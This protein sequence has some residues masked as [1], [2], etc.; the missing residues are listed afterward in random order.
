MAGLRS[1]RLC[2][3]SG[4]EAWHI[5]F[6]RRRIST[7]CTDRAGAEKVLAAFLNQ[8]SVNAPDEGFSIAEILNRYLADRQDEGIAGLERLEWAHKPLQRIWAEKPPEAIT[9]QSCRAYA[10]QRSSDGVSAGTIRTELQAL[11]AALNWAHRKGVLS[12]AP[13]IKMPPK[14]PSKSRWLTRQEA[15]ALLAE[16][17]SPHIHLFVVLALNT[18][19]RKS[20]ILGLQWHKVD[21]ERRLI[22]FSTG[23]QTN[24][25]RSKVPIN[26]TLL[27]ALEDAYKRKTTDY[28]IEYGGVPVANIKRSF[29]EACS[30]AGLKDATPHTL[31]HTA[32]TWM[33]Q[34]GV[35]LWE[36]AGFLGH[37][38]IDMV[39]KVYG[40]HHPDHLQRAAKALG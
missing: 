28:V 5:Y 4:R 40:H 35:P 10:R 6:E 32:A 26:D 30:R 16:C 3:V 18:A 8:Q 7:G 37:S 27:R 12:K 34:A 22:D 17:K 19:A 25:R 31:R 21:L 13:A 39:Q 9:D 23:V 14:P 11:R 1:A 33:A 24:K 38:S 2:R 36:V 29:M 20:A 15:D